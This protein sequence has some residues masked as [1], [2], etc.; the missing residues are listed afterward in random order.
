MHVRDKAFLEKLGRD[1][2]LNRQDARRI[3]QE[4]ARVQSMAGLDA[5]VAAVVK[6][7]TR[8]AGPVSAEDTREAVKNR[9]AESWLTYMGTIADLSRGFVQAPVI[10]LI[11]AY[12]SPRTSQPAWKS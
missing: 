9:L 2:G 4:L 5:L 3:E 11:E 1:L 6:T 8:Q 12:V 10:R 7:S